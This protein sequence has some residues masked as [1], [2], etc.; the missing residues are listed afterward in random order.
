MSK[1]KIKAALVDAPKKPNN[2][3]FKLRIEKMKEYGDDP[4]F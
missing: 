1:S 3:Y 2:A 4:K